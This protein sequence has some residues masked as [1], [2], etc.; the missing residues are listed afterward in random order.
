MRRIILFLAFILGLLS[1]NAQE[2]LDSKPSFPGGEEALATYLTENIQYPIIAAE[3]G[4]E[5][6][7]TLDFMVKSDGSIGEIKI[8]RMVDLDLEDEAVRVV[9]AMPK[10]EPATNNGIAVDA[11]FRL[12]I[13]FRL[14]TNN[15]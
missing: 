9:K 15:Q 14:P 5:G 1:A 13:K 8:V 4:I 10:W 2:Q 7:V 6:V 3:N 11:W 12:P